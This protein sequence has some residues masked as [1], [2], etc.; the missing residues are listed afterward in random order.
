MTTRLIVD[1]CELNDYDGSDLPAS[2]HVSQRDPEIDLWILRGFGCRQDAEIAKAILEK[3]PV[4]W[5]ADGIES[6]NQVQAAGY[7]GRDD[8]M[9]LVCESLRW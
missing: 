7:R 3:L 8:L 9:K 4:D 2:W 6:W 1:Y 5:G